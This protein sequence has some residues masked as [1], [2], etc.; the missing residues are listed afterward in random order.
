MNP[1]GTPRAHIDTAWLLGLVRNQTDR[2]LRLVA[3][4]LCRAIWDELSARAREAVAFAEDLADGGGTDA[5]RQHHFGHLRAEGGSNALRRELWL[6]ACTVV[7]AGRSAAEFAIG[8]GVAPEVEI[9]VIYDIFA[10]AFRPVALAPEWRTGTVTALARQIYESR[11][12]SAMPILA[13]ALQDAGCDSTDILHHCRD[14][15]QPHARGCWLVDAVLGH[16]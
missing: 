7:E 15:S 16:T 5:A 6:P 4:A 14:A 1:G 8:S 2:R 9:A 12:F 13:D 3:C 11:D 10:A